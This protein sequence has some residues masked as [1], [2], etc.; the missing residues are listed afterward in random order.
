MT[1]FNVTFESIGDFNAKFE[2]DDSFDDILENVIEI[3]KIDPYNGSYIFTPSSEEQVIEIHGKTAINDI[4]IE[5]VPNN[6]GLITWNGR[7]LTVT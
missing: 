1:V 2:N 6:Y 7:T 5:P 4:K 3:G